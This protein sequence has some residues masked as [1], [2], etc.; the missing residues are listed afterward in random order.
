MKSHS[1]NAGAKLAVILRKAGLCPIP[2]HQGTKQPS[3]GTDWGRKDY[4]PAD[5]NQKG[6]PAIGVLLGE[7]S[8]W[9]A[10]FDIDTDDDDDIDELS[11]IWRDAGVVE[12]W[13]GN[14]PVHFQFRISGRDE[15]HKLIGKKTAKLP[16]LRL[17]GRGAG[18][19]LMMGGKSREGLDKQMQVAVYGRHKSGQIVKYREYPAYDSFPVLSVSEV[20]DLWQTSVVRLGGVGNRGDDFVSDEYSDSRDTFGLSMLELAAFAANQPSPYTRGSGRVCPWC[21]DK[22]FSVFEDG[23]KCHH[24]NS[25]PSKLLV[26]KSENGVNVWQTLAFILGLD[27]REHREALDWYAFEMQQGADIRDFVDWQPKEEPWLFDVDL[28]VDEDY[29]SEMTRSLKSMGFL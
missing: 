11:G 14:R 25:C 20:D 29:L 9:L 17:D 12:V 8:G 5:F 1:S 22:T 28:E 13:R 15:N 2:L 16:Y 26:D 21:G 19:E 3:G 6:I 18:L 24:E 10:D 27:A 23:G 7:R 4:E